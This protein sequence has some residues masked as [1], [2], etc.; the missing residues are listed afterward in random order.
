VWRYRAAGTSA[1]LE[2]LPITDTSIYQSGPTESIL[3]FTKLS[4][5]LHDGTYQCEV[6][7]RIGRDSDQV[8]IE[9][10][11]ELL[12]LLFCIHNPSDSCIYLYIRLN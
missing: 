5:T 1:F 8:D 11:S 6:S 12:G 9:V 7:N 10:K 3:S 4:D 2:N